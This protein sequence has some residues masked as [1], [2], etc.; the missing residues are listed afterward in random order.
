[1]QKV[2]RGSSCCVKVNIPFFYQNSEGSDSEFLGE[3][4]A[5]LAL[6]DSSEG[7]DLTMFQ[8]KLICFESKNK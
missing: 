7:W 8:I 2:A 4:P 3:I 6:N 5:F 1:M